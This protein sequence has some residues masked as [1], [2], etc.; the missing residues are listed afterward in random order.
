MDFGPVT[1]A[2]RTK[3]SDVMSRF[4]LLTISS[5]E[6]LL[7]HAAPWDDLWRRSAVALPT[8]RA[9]TLA[10]WLRRF[11]PQ[12]A[13]RALV[14]ED[15]GQFVAALPLW[16]RRLKGVLRVAA[17]TSLPWS[18][19]GDLL[20]DESCDVAAALDLLIANAGGLPEPLL[21][22]EGVNCETARWQAWIGAAERAGW[23]VDIH[24]IC[25]VAVADAPQG[26]EAYA[27][28]LSSDFQRNLR[29]R[30][31]Q[32]EE[33]GT[34]RLRS[35]A[36]LGMADVASALR[37]ACEVEDQGWKG[38]EGTSILRTPGMFDFFLRQA[39]C[40]R[41]WDQWALHFLELND[42]PIAFELGYLGKGTYF[43]HKVS[44]AP[45][46]RKLAPGHVLRWHL[47]PRLFAPDLFR[48]MDFFGR[49]TEAAERWLT[50]RYTVSRLVACPR[51]LTSRV[52]MAAYAKLWPQVRRWRQKA[53]S[54]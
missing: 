6:E 8:L 51:R 7:R 32:L 27:A 35:W 52:L 3:L 12:A 28:G 53:A 24:P 36:E 5:A 16:R 54:G 33:L 4:R 44:Y 40:L 10:I 2:F 48:R 17:L 29:R 14:V 20:L 19:S 18:P 9:E 46:H 45:E 42:R 50:G 30:A 11:A 39:E 49:L 34:F 31:R 13:F 22:L 47:L 41:R 38:A 26:W 43:A 15:S 1:L 37:R 23:P 21:W 25:D